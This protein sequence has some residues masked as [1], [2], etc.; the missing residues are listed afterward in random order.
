MPRTTPRKPTQLAS[1]AE[2]ADRLAVNRRTIY[3][4]VNDG[5][6]TGWR[7]GPKLIKVDLAELDKLI[8]PVAAAG[9]SDAA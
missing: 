6:I 1:I 7:V 2:A 9:G 5:L 3:R 4:W 8:T